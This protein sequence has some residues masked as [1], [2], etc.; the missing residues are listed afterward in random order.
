MSARTPF[1]VGNW[2]MNGLRS[3]LEELE[4]IAVGV[5]AYDG[6][7][8]AVCLPAT[9]IERAWHHTKGIEIGAQDCHMFA[10]GAFT[11]RVSASMLFDAGARVV[12]LGHSECRTQEI[13]TD[14]L[15]RQK[16]ESALSVGLAA[17]ICVGETQWARRHRNECIVVESQLH[18]SL[19]AAHSDKLA[20]AYEPTWAIGTGRT[21]TTEEIDA[22]HCVIRSVLTRKYGESADGIPIL[23]GG[24]A[25]PRNASALLAIDAVD[26]LL[27]GGASLH[28]ESFLPIVAAAAAI[29]KDLA[30]RPQ[31]NAIAR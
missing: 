17:I 10:E 5:A 23:Y 12:I 27:V 7:R 9:L 18:G 1:L 8:V 29:A 19:P 22:M 30:A 25:G 24:S 28:A 11:G 26:G 13:E 14:E 16:A 6:V 15:V 3:S 2:K 21:P 20:V 4:K 31:L